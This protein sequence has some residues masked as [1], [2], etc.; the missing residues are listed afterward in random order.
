MLWNLAALGPSPYA[1]FIATVNADNNRETVGSVTNKLQNYESMIS[2]PMQA[3]VSAMV[4]ELRE[5]IREK[6][7]GETRGQPLGFWSRSYRRSKANYTPTEKEILAA[8][9][10]VQAASEVIDTEAQLLLA[11]WLLVLGW[12][13]K[14]KVPSTHHATNATWS[15]WI[16]LITQCTHIGNPNCPEILEVITNWLEGENFGPVHEDEQEQVTHAEE[17]PPYN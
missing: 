6:V 5:E 17:A 7:S 3:H 1:T 15:K 11:P 12:M 9:E 10:G 13:F 4:K 14:G 8:Y 2:G 16:A